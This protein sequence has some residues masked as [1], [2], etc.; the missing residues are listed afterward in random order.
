[1]V[2]L[3]RA[4]ISH[5]KRSYQRTTAVGQQAKKGGLSLQFIAGIQLYYSTL[6]LCRMI[7]NLRKTDYG[8]PF[9]ILHCS[10]FNKPLQNFSLLPCRQKFTNDQPTVLCLIASVV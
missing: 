8:F 6:C 1:M 3:V 4:P 5:R 9:P 2:A 10:R 7:A